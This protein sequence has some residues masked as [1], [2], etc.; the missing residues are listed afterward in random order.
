MMENKF[1]NMDLQEIE[2]A[3]ENE[4]FNTYVSQKEGLEYCPLDN[5]ACAVYAKKDL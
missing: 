5:I 2:N 1:T 4:P 3:I